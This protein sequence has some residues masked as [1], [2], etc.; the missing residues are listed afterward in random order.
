MI[1]VSILSWSGIFF[2][3]LW[4]VLHAPDWSRKAFVNNTIFSNP[5]KP[6]TR[7]IRHTSLQHKRQYLM[8]NY[9]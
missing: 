4:T 8:L 1:L 2:E 3:V 7:N 9:E 6:L 5:T